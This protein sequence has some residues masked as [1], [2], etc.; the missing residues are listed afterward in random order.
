MWVDLFDNEVVF[1]LQ[2]NGKPRPKSLNS[3]CIVSLPPVR[4]QVRSG[5]EDEVK[6]RK[7]R[8]VTAQCYSH[9]GRRESS[10]RQRYKRM[11]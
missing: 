1:E 5:G 7:K 3:I 9:N 11:P 2:C 8:H 10:Q 4:K 6:R